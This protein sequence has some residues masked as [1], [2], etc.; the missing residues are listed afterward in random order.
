MRGTGSRRFKKQESVERRG[1]K[2]LLACFFFFPF[3]ASFI[4]FRLLSFTPLA[5]SFARRNCNIE[6][7]KNGRR[8]KH[9]L[10]AF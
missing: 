5:Y 4:P 3:R 10:K 6:L 2:S 1:K 8:E 9:Q 7:H